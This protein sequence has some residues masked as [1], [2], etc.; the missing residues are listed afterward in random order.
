MSTASASPNKTFTALIKYSRR[1]SLRLNVPPPAKRRLPNQPAAER[2]LQAYFVN[3]V[4][5]QEIDRVGWSGT[6]NPKSRKDFVM[7]VESNY[8]GDKVNYFLQRHF[9]TTLTRDGATLHHQVTIDLINQ[10]VCGSYVRTSYL[11]NLRLY[12]GQDAS[13]LSG[14]LLPVRYANPA[15]PSGTS[16]VDG[17]LP[18]IMCHGGHG[19]AV[20]KYDTQWQVGAGSTYSIYWQKQPGTVSDTIDVS[21][22]DGSGHTYTVG[23]SLAQ[24]QLIKL[25]PAGVTLTAGQPA[26][27]TLPRLSLG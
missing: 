11:V 21:W 5:Q 20:F 22:A 15:S 25:S 8:Y 9:T 12:V 4:T 19:Q 23:G 1:T 14:N 16:L 3:P 27:G 18:E 17:W 2:H 7:D 13:A 26:Q 10:T 6:V 24:D